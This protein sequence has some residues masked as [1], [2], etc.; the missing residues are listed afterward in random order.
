[1]GQN[2]PKPTQKWS[3]LMSLI[4]MSKM[5]E[6]ICLNSIAKIAAIHGQGGCILSRLNRTGASHAEHSLDLQKWLSHAI[7]KKCSSAGMAVIQVGSTWFH[8]YE[9]V[10]CLFTSCAGQTSWNEPT[11]TSA[12]SKWSMVSPWKLKRDYICICIYIYVYI[13]RTFILKFIGAPSKLCDAQVLCE[14]WSVSHRLR[15]WLV[16]HDLP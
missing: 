6:C 3:N 15:M 7:S 1:M 12:L 14:L 10:L 2:Y 5:F 9:S 13:I 4:F 11:W 16:W 8:L